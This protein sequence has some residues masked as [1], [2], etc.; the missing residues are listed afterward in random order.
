[1]HLYSISSILPKETSVSAPHCLTCPALPEARPKAQV[2][3]IRHEHVTKHQ[4]IFDVYEEEQQ[5]TNPPTVEKVNKKRSKRKLNNAIPIFVNWCI[6]I[7]FSRQYPAIP[8]TEPEPLYKPCTYHNVLFSTTMAYFLLECL[9]PGIPTVTLFA[10]H[11][12]NDSNVTMGTV[13][14]PR[15]LLVLQNNTKLYVSI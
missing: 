12:Q 6:D 1:M 8:Q 2:A 13:P 15:A 10:T 7:N 9:G 14:L 4:F 3:N 5:E 11:D